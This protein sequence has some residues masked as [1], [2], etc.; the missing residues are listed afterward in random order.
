MAYSYRIFETQLGS[1]AIVAT[2]RGV[3]RV[4]TNQRSAAQLE[5]LVQRDCPGATE[6]TDLLPELVDS[7]QR[8]YEG[9]CVSFDKTPIDWPAA[10]PFELAAWKACRR[11]PYGKTISYAEL[12]ARAGN[13]RAAR[14]A[15][16][17]MR[18]NPLGIVVP[19]HRVIRSDGTLGGFSAPAGLK[20]KRRL[21]AMEGAPGF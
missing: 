20:L 9:Q 5:G 1:A 14:A 7:L 13:P 3:C 16:M 18:H 4:Y 15:G 8:Y 10:G 6:N 17:A 19:C 21:L 2:R 11:V 12:A